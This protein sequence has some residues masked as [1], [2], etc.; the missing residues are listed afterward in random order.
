MEAPVTLTALRAWLCQHLCI[1]AQDSNASNCSESSAASHFPQGPG[2]IQKLH[3]LGPKQTLS[4]P[5]QQKRCHIWLLKNRN[6]KMV[7]P[8][9]WKHRHLRNPSWVI[10]SHTHFGTETKLNQRGQRKRSKGQISGFKGYDPG[11]GPTSDSTTL[12]KSTPSPWQQIK[13]WQGP[14]LS[15]VETAPYCGWTK[16]CTL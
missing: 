5:G 14:H 4:Q 3:I 9:K 2:N 1:A 7:C 6:S 8:G 13:K 16:S 10:L 12:K 11:P 15:V